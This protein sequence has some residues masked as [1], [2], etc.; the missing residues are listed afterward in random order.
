MSV[1]EE[2]DDLDEMELKGI[3]KRSDHEPGF[4]LGFLAAMDD[5]RF[6]GAFS[7]FL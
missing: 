5:L 4:Y 3:E 1:M 6:Y 2:F 7:F